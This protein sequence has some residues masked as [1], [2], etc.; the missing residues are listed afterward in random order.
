MV[1]YPSLCVDNFYNDPDSIVEFALSCNFSVDTDGRWPGQRTASLNHVNQRFFHDFVV[2]ILSLLYDFNY[3]KASYTVE[4]TFQLI[5]PFTQNPKST[6][7]QGWVHYDDNAIFA[8]IIYLNK[9]ISL[10]HGTSLYQPNANFDLEYLQT[11][12]KTKS[13]LYLGQNPKHYHKTFKEHLKM[14]DKVV[15][16]KNVYNRLILFDA[17]QYH[18]ADF[19]AGADSARLTQTFFIQELSI[20]APT[21]YEKIRSFLV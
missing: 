6:K 1:Q 18:A 12:L 8:G 17:S 5:K 3:H 7:N 9:D 16:Y 10:D 14:F 19:L 11:T 13:D 20:D 4:S 2:K 15:T 21:P